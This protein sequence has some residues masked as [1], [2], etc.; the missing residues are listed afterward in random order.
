[1]ED[2]EEI[3]IEGPDFIEWNNSATYK[4]SNEADAEFEVEW[5]SKIKHDMPIFTNN[6]VTIKIKDKYSGDIKITANTNGQIIEKTVY[7][8]TI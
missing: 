2:T 8:K 5:F 7:I 4:L 3:Y 1:M 6:S